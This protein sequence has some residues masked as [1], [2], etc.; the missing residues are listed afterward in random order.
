MIP[1]HDCDQ[2]RA[3]DQVLI[4]ELDI[5]GRQL[6]EIAGYMCARS[7][8]ERWPR[9]GVAL[10]C[11]PGNNGGDGFV[12][13]RWLHLWSHDVQV[14]CSAPPKT[15]DS[16]ENLRL[17][18][19][20]GIEPVA[21]PAPATVIVDALL[22]TGQDRPPVGAIADRVHEI[23]ERSGPGVKIV[24]IDLPTGMCGQ[25]GSPLDADCVIRADLTLTLGFLKP[26]LLLRPG[27]GLVGALECVDIGLSQARSLHPRRFEPAAWLLED[28]DIQDWIPHRNPGDAKWNQGHV[29]IRGGGG[30]AVLAAHGAFRAGA[31]LVTLI[32]PQREWAD[33]HGLWPE[34]I[35]AEELEPKRHDVL[36]LGPGLGLEHSDEVL[37][38]WTTFSG[39]VVADADALTVLAQQPTVPTPAG[40]RL[41]TPHSAEAARLLKCSR[42]AVDADRLTALRALQSWG[43]ALLKGPHTLISGE[44]IWVNPTGSSVLATA[45]SGDVLAGHI[46]GYAARGL[47]LPQSAAVA[48]WRHGRASERLHEN[49]TASDLVEALC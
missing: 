27:L 12:I 21:V 11:G 46:A 18:R 40:P 39:P 32:A 49:T 41:I 10:Y 42:D 24:A 2:I 45:G 30:A 36:V 38:H 33:L 7:I 34:V 1:V 37:H 26:G 20:L 19:A 17:L 23:R 4:S 16:I 25:T 35:L 22:G 5:P 6:M 13:A 29:A 9:A 14:V 3:C 48:A 43:D 28:G 47:S 15:V 44:A 31:G 8:H